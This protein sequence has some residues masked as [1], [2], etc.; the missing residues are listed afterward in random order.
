MNLKIRINLI[1]TLMLALVMLLGAGMMIDNAREDVRAEVDSTTVLALHLLDAEVLHYTSD[2]TW[3]NSDK[4]NTVSIFR[5]QSLDNVRHLRIE[6][7]DSFGRLRDSNRPP[8][9][10]GGNSPPVWFEKIMSKVSSSLK[11]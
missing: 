3:A 8:T 9:S 6:F 10:R 1:I 2:Y 5:L 4:K 11:A 7:F